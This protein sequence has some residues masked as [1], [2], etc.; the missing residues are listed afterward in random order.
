MTNADG[1]TQSPPASRLG[2]PATLAAVERW[3]RG[4]MAR[5]LGCGWED[6]GKMIGE[7]GSG[8]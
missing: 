6:G 3:G 8:R 4:K 5:D 1:P 2:P 7:P